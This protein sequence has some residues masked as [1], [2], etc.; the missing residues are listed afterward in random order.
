[1]G[2]P[3]FVLFL[4]R[5]FMDSDQEAFFLGLNYDGNS[6]FQGFHSWKNAKAL[7]IP[8]RFHEEWGSFIFG[9]CMIDTFPKNEQDRLLWSWDVAS[10]TLTTKGPYEALFSSRCPT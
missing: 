5:S 6:L 9:L 1:M 3:L 10:S 2:G 8:V 7:N 4:V